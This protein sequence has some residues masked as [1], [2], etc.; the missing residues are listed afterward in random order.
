MKPFSPHPP[1][2]I[3]ARF[4]WAPWVLGLAAAGTV[5]A[6]SAIDLAQTAANSAPNPARRGAMLAQL[7]H[8]LADCG[9]APRAR[10]IALSVG[11]TLRDSDDPASLHALTIAAALLVRLGDPKGAE[12][13]ARSTT[14]RDQRLQLLGLLG[15]DFAAAQD[16]THL[17]E[18]LALLQAE[19]APPADEDSDAATAGTPPSASARDERKIAALTTIGMA[20]ANNGQP[21]RALALAKALPKGADRLRVLTQ[22]ALSFCKHGPAAGGAELARQI[23][24]E[25]S[26]HPAGAASVMR[27]GPS[28]AA[29]AAAACV[30]PDAARPIL[31]S[32]PKPAAA[33]LRAV[34]LLDAAGLFGAADALAAPPDPADAH[35]L[36]GAAQR[37]LLQG[38]RD[39]AKR[40]ALQAAHLAALSVP[41]T[42]AEAAAGPG[43]DQAAQQSETFELL[44]G[45]GAYDEAV[46]II[47]TLPPEDQRG[48]VLNLLRV[49]ADRKDSAALAKTF[50]VV[51][52]LMQPPGA[53]QP[54]A[55]KSLCDMALILARAGQTA[56][57]RAAFD[58]ARTPPPGSAPDDPDLIGRIATV[59]A[60]L[61]DLPGALKTAASAGPLLLPGT[62]TPPGAAQPG[63][64]ALA[65]VHIA[66]A[67]A[68]AG[69][70]GE[71]V[72]AETALGP[73]LPALHDQ[74]LA[75][76][77]QAQAGE[78]QQALASSA[79]ISDASLR[80]QP[81]L[82]LS[83]PAG[84]AK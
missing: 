73:G 64:Q 83:C 71:A 19:P 22:S 65:L 78:P 29:T 18:I 69:R 35:S 42:G 58:A 68:D 80:F 72:Q 43:P 6:A 44:V 41:A 82:A 37:R 2:S 33:R 57:A 66:I 36:L 1:A 48:F 27:G 70:P 21:A 61:S 23:K 59:Q 31:Q 60:V 47:R 25:A 67:M 34:A 11:T 55:R 63:P 5:P 54:A 15:A 16:A 62:G 13:L 40:L 24:D 46:A 77:A 74:A 50:P 20:L 28:L 52:G 8:A 4:R 81:L 79:R 39:G 30:G 10:A 9:N 75:A 3:W 7:A 12:D 76:I 32:T 14:Q 17:A 49:E 45:L 53:A 84:K 26:F 38:D 56:S 51:L